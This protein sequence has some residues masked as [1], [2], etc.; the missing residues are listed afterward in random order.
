ME[1]ATAN[2]LISSKMNSQMRVIL[3]PLVLLT[4]SDY[5]TRHTLRGQSGPIVGALL[6]RQRGCDITVEN[7]F[8]CHMRSAPAVDGGYLLDDDRFRSRL[9]QMAAVHAERQLD[10]V[11]WYTLVPCSGPTSTI[12]PIH[13]QI[14]RGWN[15]SAI[16]LAFHPEEAALRSVGGKLPLTVYESR[17]EVDGVH[18]DQDGEDRT[19]DYGEP[20]TLKLQFCKVPHSV[21]SDETEMISMNYVASAQG[22]A[23]TTATRKGRPARSVEMN[24]KGK[25]RLVEGRADGAKTEKGP[26]EDSARL[27]REEEYMIES[28]VTKANSIRMLHSRIR[29]LL[30]YLE[31]LPDALTT[32]EQDDPESMDTDS[33]TPSL[34]ILRR[35][36]AL[37]GS[38]GLV[39]PSNQEAYDQGMDRKANDVRLMGLLNDVMQEVR[40]ARSV[41]KKVGIIESAKAGRRRASAGHFMRSMHSKNSMHSMNPA[42]SVNPKHSMNST[43]PKSP[44]HTMHSPRPLNSMNSMQTLYALDGLGGMRF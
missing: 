6:G 27:T 16:L 32:G 1:A 31:R 44:K 10:F 21:E 4:I 12:L 22:R 35:I 13:N 11:G 5:I 37:V 17:Y 41:G 26:A 43:N 23:S 19:M 34:P 8:E 14:L 39:I 29:L 9:K 28:L 2:P 15:E 3:H 42:H 24:S 30:A 38:L 33:I 7:A 18:N 20:A 36:Q 40:Q 25:R